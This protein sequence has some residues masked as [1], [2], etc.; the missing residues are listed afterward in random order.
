MKKQW[1]LFC[2]GIGVSTVIAWLLLNKPGGMWAAWIFGIFFGF[3]MQRSRFC[4]TSM[5][6]D[7]FLFGFKRPSRALALLILLTTIGFALVRWWKTINGI[8]FTAYWEPW[9]WGTV[10]G[11]LMFG[12]GMVLAG[13]CASGMLMRMGEGYAMQWLAFVFFLAGT[14]IAV[15]SFPLWKQGLGNALD[16]AGLWPGFIIIQIAVLLYFWRRMREE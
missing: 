10:I 15:I 1:L 2:I 4:M 5:L 11:G 7:Y 12:I 8:P 14:G 13:G 9:G 16:L 3:V 6:R